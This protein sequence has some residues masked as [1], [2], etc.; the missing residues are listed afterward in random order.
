MIV[1]AWNPLVNKR[2]FTDGAYSY[3]D[4]Y[5]K[6]LRMA[7]GKPRAYLANSYVP[8][9]FDGVGLDLDD[10]R[11]IASV[12]TKYNTERKQFEYWFDFSL[13]YGSLPFQIPRLLFP[14]EAGVRQFVPGSLSFGVIAPHTAAFALREAQ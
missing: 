1:V 7:S 8:K 6:E 2:F 10:E 11:V 5:I 13:R 14:S 12:S 3:D 9:V 4:E